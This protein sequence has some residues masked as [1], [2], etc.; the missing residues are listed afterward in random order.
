MQAK[1]VV[2]RNARTRI[3]NKLISFML[4]TKRRR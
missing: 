4:R 3:L 1:Y 2:S